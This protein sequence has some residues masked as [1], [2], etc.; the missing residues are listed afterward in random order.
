[1][2]NWFKDLGIIKCAFVAKLDQ[3][4]NKSIYGKKIVLFY[5]F[6]F[7]DIKGS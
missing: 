4:K 3:L 7:M 1:M 5:S 6:I 2:F